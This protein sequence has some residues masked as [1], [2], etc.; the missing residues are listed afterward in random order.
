MKVGELIALLQEHDP[1]LIVQAVGDG[2]ESEWAVV[3]S[4]EE[5]TER[6]IITYENGISQ[7]HWNVKVLNIGP[8]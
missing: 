2:F 1:E 3:T 8:Y 4:V 7:Q 5:S 6:L